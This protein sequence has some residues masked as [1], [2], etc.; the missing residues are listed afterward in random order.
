MIAVNWESD[1]LCNNSFIDD[2]ERI[3]LGFAQKGSEN[4]RKLKFLFRL[5]GRR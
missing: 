3:P 4:T 5:D 1:I 2:F